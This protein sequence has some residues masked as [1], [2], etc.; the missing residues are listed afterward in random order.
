MPAAELR[1]W[2]GFAELEPFGPLADDFRAGS[3]CAA[4]LNPHRKKDA[5]PLTA[6]DFMPALAATLHPPE[7]EDDTPLTPEQAAAA[8]DAFFGF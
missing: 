4:A 8:L 3:I 6:A 7:E 2:M 5:K 1:E